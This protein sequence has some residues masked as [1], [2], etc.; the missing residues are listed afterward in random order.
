[1]TPERW[2]IVFWIVMGLCC[3]ALQYL[4][5]VRPLVTRLD[6]LLDVLRHVA[7]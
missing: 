7:R 5:V 1:M 2:Y 6:A 4:V 3:L